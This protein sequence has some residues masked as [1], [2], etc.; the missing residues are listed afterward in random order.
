[1]RV[2]LV[3]DESDIRE[4]LAARLRDEGYTVDTAAANTPWIWELSTLDYLSFPESK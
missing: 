4:P 3:E 2:L 1:M